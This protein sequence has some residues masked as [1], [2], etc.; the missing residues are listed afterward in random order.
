MSHILVHASLAKRTETP[1]VRPLS[2]SEH[3]RHVV[4]RYHKLPDAGDL[5]MYVEELKYVKHSPLDFRLLVNRRDVAFCQ[6]MR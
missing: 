2:G 5:Q 1:A 4:L 3:N 6:G